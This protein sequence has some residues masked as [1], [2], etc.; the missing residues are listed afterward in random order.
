MRN[1]VVVFGDQLNRNS[2]V[3][4]GFDK[5]RD[6]VWMSEVEE[7]ATHVWCH[8]QR[9]VL[10]FA[11]MRHFRNQLAK[12]GFPLH[13]H[14]LTT[15]RAADRGAGFAAILH[16]D[17]RKLRPERIIA[18][19]PGDYRVMRILTETAEK[20]DIPLEMRPD[21]HF[22]CS[23]DEFKRLANR[24]KRFLM[25]TFY[26]SMRKQH[27]VLMTEEGK[28][29]GDQWNFDK[30][31][32]ETFGEA[33]PDELPSPMSFKPDAVTKQVLELVDKRF[34]KH[35]GRVD[36]FDLPVTAEN[37]RKMLK[38]FI[39]HALPLFGKF[40]DAM[41]TGQPFLHHSRLSSSLN[42]KLLNPREC[43]DRAVQAYAT[44]NAPLNSV[45]GFIR[46]IL[47]WR[48]YVRGI[49]WLH[50][51][52]Y[53]KN[54]FFSHELDVPRFFWTGD[55][56]M[57]CV[58]EIMQHVLDHGYAHHIERLM[59]LGLLAQLIG[60]HPRRF[61]DWHMGM[62]LDAVDWVSL[63]NALGM[64]QYGDGGIVGTK[65]YCATGNYI[66]RMSNYCKTCVYS[67]KDAVGDNACPFTTLY[68][69][70]LDRHYQ[71]LK[72]NPRLTFQIRNLEKKRQD[73]RLMDSLRARAGDLRKHWYG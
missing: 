54:N 8:K 56:E 12:R 2:S 15:R 58:R 25:E 17:L 66:N 26:R 33:G 48:E 31:N 19:Q 36:R 45:E 28:P 24:S 32:R 65:P 69:D 67:Y 30:D 3:F 46:Q 70:F 9:I 5:T 63:P 16:K 61:H 51:P 50:M 22:F 64:S 10:F 13:Y 27:A 41:W 18:V 59:V 42:L 52:E 34:R 20:T 57:V 43:V 6:R 1:L 14:E 73:A 40:E 21:L 4:S 29:L 53:A 60:V 39:N 44:G 68:W 55:T 35:P 11:S 7:E 37:A 47:G 62:Y 72:Q 49:Y 38:H 23:V 71:K